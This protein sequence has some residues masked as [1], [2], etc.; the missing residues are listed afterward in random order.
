MCRFR[1]F[2]YATQWEAA[3]VKKINRNHIRHLKALEDRHEETIKNNMHYDC[4]S[5]VLLQ[6]QRSL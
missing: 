5:P 1:G 4:N 2:C 6:M 3:A